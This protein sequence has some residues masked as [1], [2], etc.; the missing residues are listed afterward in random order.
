MAFAEK[1]GIEK[2]P[3]DNQ[4][5]ETITGERVKQHGPFQALDAM[6]A[7]PAMPQMQAGTVVKHY[8]FIRQLGAG[9]MGTV[10]LARD[11]RLGRL[12]AVKV[13][14]KYTGQAAFR[15]LEE[16]RTTALC[17]HENIVVVYDV[18]EY[19][20][21]P[22]MVLEYIAGRTLRAAMNEH[23]ADAARFAVKTMLPV[24]RALVC[25][26][27]M[28]IVHRDL[29]PENIL[30]SPD[31][32]IK[33][34]DFGIA[35]QISG[36][37][38]DPGE[39]DALWTG[40]HRSQQTKDGALVGTLAYMA[41]EQLLGQTVDERTDIWAVGVIL[42][43]I[44][45]GR[46][47]FN[48]MSHA[49]IIDIMR[50]TE[51]VPGIREH[52][53]NLGPLADIVDRCLQKNK[54]ARF[55]SAKELLEALERVAGGKT[56]TTAEDE[57]PFAG[58]SAFQETDAPR[59]FGRDADI[60]AVLTKLRHQELIVV[61]GPS[62]AGKS[63]FVRAGILPALKQSD[64][65]YETWSVRPGRQ[66][67]AALAEALAFFAE[68]TTP[69]DVA[70]DLDPAA[71]ANILRTQPGY[72]GMKLRARCR[73][74]VANP[75]LGAQ[76]AAGDLKP[77][78]FNPGLGAQGAA[79]DL[80][81]QMFDQRIV[82]FVDQFEELY[83]LGADATERAAFC[84]CL[85]GVADD[86]ASPLRVI[87]T[88]RADFLERLTEN[89]HF[90]AAV[91]RGLVFLPPMGP[92]ALRD[93]LVKPLEL[94]HYAFE[95]AK[96]VDEM[97]A[98]LSGTKSPLP[99]LQFT[100]SKWWDARDRQRRLLTRDAYQRLGG[101]AGALSTHAD[102]VLM[103][104]SSAEQRLVRAIFQRLV[105]VER[106]RAIVRVDELRSLF[107][108]AAAVDHVITH[109]ADARL[110]SI[111]SSHDGLEKNVELTHES[112]VER[113]GTLRAWLD[114]NEQHAQF[115]AE[116]RNAAQQWEKHGERE[117][118]L[119]RDDAASNAALWLKRSRMNHADGTIDIGKREQRYL[120]AV[121]RL[122]ERTRR[123]RRQFVA[124]LVTAIAAVAVVV[125]ML[126]IRA[127]DQARR[128]DDQARRADTRA[129][130]A[131]EG[132]RRARN[133]TRMAAA[134]GL[135]EDPTTM[136]AVLREMETGP[137][138]PGWD[139]LVRWARAAGIAE[140][141]IHGEDKI[142]DL[143]LSSDGRLGAADSDLR[144]RV[145]NSDFVHA[146]IEFRGHD[147][148]I[149]GIAWSPDGRRIATASLDKTVRVQNADGTGEPMVLRFATPALDVAWSPNGRQIA[150]AFGDKPLQIWNSDGIGKPLVFRD[151]ALAGAIKFS[152]D[153]ESIVSI[154]NDNVVQIWNAAGK[155]AP[156]VLDTHVNDFDISPD[157]RH[158]VTASGD[159][160]V[161]V[162]NNHG[163]GE[164]R[165]LRG[166]ENAVT[167]V[168]F[169]ADGQRIVSGS[170]DRTIRI[171][172]R[173]G[174]SRPTIFRGH[175]DKIVTLRVGSDGH[176]VSY[177]YDMTLRWWQLEA[178]DRPR[179]LYGH[180]GAIGWTSYSP[181][182]RHILSASLDK[183]VRLWQ[184][185]GSGQTAVF[186]GHSDAVNAA[187]YSADGRRFVTASNDKTVRIWNI[188][189]HDD[190]IVLRGHTAAVNSAVFSPDG[191]RVVSASHDNTVRVWNA[192]G[193]G[194][195]L[196]LRGH[197]HI[198]YG[199]A[200]SPDGQQVVSASQDRTVR[201]W[202]ADGNG[203]PIVLRGHTGGVIGG[204]VYSPDGK[205]IV[206][207]SRDKTLRIWNADGTG[208]PIVL[209]G[210]DALVLVRGD[211]PFSPDGKRVVSSSDDGTVRIWNVDGTG[212]PIV[213]R[214]SDKPIETASFSPD[215]RSIVAAGDDLTITI[216]TDLDS[217]LSA[218][219]SRLWSATTYCM[220]LDVRKTLLGFS[221]EQSR[222][223]IERCRQ[224][225]K[226]AHKVAATA[227]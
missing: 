223:D 201:I 47:P 12:V 155:T 222:A 139:E 122:A 132:A 124:V 91:T 30:L 92:D 26:H 123:R 169:T 20:G 4:E 211:N 127:R 194:E 82:L 39:F 159:N 105:T 202:N 227:N 195:P 204:A 57:R 151:N 164:P 150:I 128:A 45:A 81:P 68:P 136:L 182:G 120:E 156:I 212:D 187:S 142:N 10:F 69:G 176:L 152:P 29:K 117:G 53:P 76:G 56:N 125:S 167:A 168:A 7:A 189:G 71:V 107:E 51:N 61:T 62:G 134:R 173:N 198:V 86:A 161:R 174:T 196:V 54:S 8:E 49:Q 110:L 137:L 27:A 118:F 100:M 119:W 188:A 184:A 85:E 73:K 83:T 116:L 74:R 218:A 200:F 147:A 206:S 34:L 50:A 66:P 129:N 153:G 149:R 21:Y 58:L 14:L 221:D 217:Y 6:A 63:S 135:E 70:E 181:D 22:Y 94:V 97:L 108:D 42:Y 165:I 208:E 13:L 185:D 214:L 190:P 146:P 93:A 37:L 112:L 131:E 216:V 59:F 80:K 160:T 18:D 226:K 55:S 77:Q 60:A 89:R 104:L 19:D 78:M 205:R 103:S 224:N 130:E 106:T 113:W 90:L 144:T 210:H 199:A 175:G 84:A 138:P 171:W 24:V 17:R 215:G 35:K 177:S 75:G 98:G 186:Q 23:A 163:T 64:K 143:A 25:A 192:D 141:V 52:C 1:H 101:V 2:V 197:E 115:L 209:R 154:A 191:R 183:T 126:A 140:V 36:A 48:G 40:E 88:M 180:E 166:H 95:D 102:A 225:V 99:I 179:F 162:W 219:D 11:T 72:L 148:S 33:V 38:P 16:A 114:M 170:A 15:F 44:V 111:E 32:P 145:W 213:L 87:V 5:M 178:T 43:E 203:E 193:S 67:L 41:P 9:G 220:P 96:L 158:I 172:N 31:G 65:P 133:A 79:G 109:L 46:R 121:V 157:G 28:G 3:A 207:G